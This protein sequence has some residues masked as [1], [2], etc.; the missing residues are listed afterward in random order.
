MNHSR[1]HYVFSRHLK[2]FNGKEDLLTRLDKNLWPNSNL[3]LDFWHYLDSLDHDDMDR[4]RAKVNITVESRNHML[5]WLAEEVVGEKVLR[6]VHLS[7]SALVY[8]ATCELISY[9]RLID[10]GQLLQFVPLFDGFKLKGVK[11]YHLMAV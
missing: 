10:Q 4:I 6:C 9:H 5:S 2:H 8:L 1:T 11:P 3:V 7:T